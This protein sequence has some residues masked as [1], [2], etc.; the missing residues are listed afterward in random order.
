MQMT[1]MWYDL[2]EKEQQIFHE[3]HGDLNLQSNR[4]IFPI[5]DC[6][7]FVFALCMWLMWAVDAGWL[8]QMINVNVS[9]RSPKQDGAVIGLLTK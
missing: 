3:N 7:L 2:T 8:M 6:S 9:F 4:P 5:E 1:Y